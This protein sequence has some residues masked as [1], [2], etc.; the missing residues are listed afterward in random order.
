MLH[1]FLLK[2][3]M[4]HLKMYL[5]LICCLLSV[6]STCRG[7]EKERPKT[8]QKVGGPCQGCEAIFEYGNKELSAVDTLPGF[9]ENKPK[10]KLTG[11]VFEKDGKTPAENVILY[12]YHTNR[13]GIYEKRGDEKGW[14]RRH[15]YI[16]GWAKTGKD[17]K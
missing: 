2:E 14:A 4:R 13:K 5:L 11:T 8:Q 12:I 7:Q 16:R 3:I 15:G 10:L 17:G 1:N 6:F 9:Q